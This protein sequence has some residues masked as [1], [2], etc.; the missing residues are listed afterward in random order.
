[1]HPA[2]VPLL[3]CS[4]MACR[5]RRYKSAPLALSLHWAMSVKNV[6]HVP[7]NSSTN[8]QTTCCRAEALRPQPYCL[9]HKLTHTD[10]PIRPQEQRFL[11]HSFLATYTRAKIW[12]ILFRKNSGREWGSTA[13]RESRKSRRAA[14]LSWLHDWRGWRTAFSITC[15]CEGG[16]EVGRG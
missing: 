4:S 16:E 6:G 11:V 12:A 1:M 7:G 13:R 2:S 3:T 8:L 14:R 15:N 5:Q 9:K 10:T